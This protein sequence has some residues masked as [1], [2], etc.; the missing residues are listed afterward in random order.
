MHQ[1][2]LEDVLSA[3]NLTSV[4]DYSFPNNCRCWQ[5]L[6]CHRDKL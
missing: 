1:T 2:L 3:G 6:N 5:Y 4:V